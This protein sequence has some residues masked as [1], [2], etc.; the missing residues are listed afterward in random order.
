MRKLKDLH[1]A[2]LKYPRLL[3][4]CKESCLLF[5]YN[6]FLSTL[7]CWKDMMWVITTVSQLPCSLVTQLSIQQ[8]L[9][10]VECFLTVLSAVFALG[11][12]STKLGQVSHGGVIFEECCCHLN[13]T[14]AMKMQR[15]PVALHSRNLSLTSFDKWCHTLTSVFFKWSL[16]HIQ[17]TFN[18]SSNSWKTY[19]SVVFLFWVLTKWLGELHVASIKVTFIFLRDTLSI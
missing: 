15:L 10:V 13:I 8:S 7:P 12:L 5:H 17:T 6:F 18:W 11:W 19:M 1:S 3:T 9:L 2:H 16:V 4:V 14:T